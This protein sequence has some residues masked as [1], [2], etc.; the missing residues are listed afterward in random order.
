MTEKENKMIDKTPNVTCE[1]AYQPF[2]VIFSVDILKTSGL[3]GKH[4]TL[5][6]HFHDS[7]KVPHFAL[8]G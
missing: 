1:L 3:N 6:C 7:E 8:Y 4:Q 5:P 2:W